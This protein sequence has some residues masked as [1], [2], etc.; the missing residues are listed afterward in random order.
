MELK[1]IKLTKPLNE[2]PGKDFPATPAGFLYEWTAQDDAT[3]YI[4]SYNGDMF[5]G[6]IIVEANEA[7]GTPSVKVG[8]QIFENGLWYREVTCKHSDGNNQ[9]SECTPLLSVHH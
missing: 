3:I 7:P 2:K 1:M 9:C 4:G 6:Y 5:V 8:N